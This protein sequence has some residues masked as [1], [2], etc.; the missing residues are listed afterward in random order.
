MKKRTLK[1]RLRSKVLDLWQRLR[2]GKDDCEFCLGAKKG[3][4]GNENVFYAAGPNGTE[5][6][7]V[8]D[9]CSVLLNNILEWR[10]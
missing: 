3:M 7:L 6:V 5:R 4:P 2:Y 10:P 9:Y 1:M 8:C